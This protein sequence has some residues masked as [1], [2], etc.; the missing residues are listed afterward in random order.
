MAAGVAARLHR[1]SRRRTRRRLRVPLSGRSPRSSCGATTACCARSRTCAATAAARSATGRRTGLDGVALPVP[2]LDVGPRRSSARGAVAAGVRRARTTTTGL[3]RVA[4]DTWGPMVFVN[5]DRGR[6]RRSPT[7]S[8]ACPATSP[9]PASTSSA[10]TYL[11]SLPVPC[12]WKVVIDGFSET[13]HVQGIHREMLAIVDDVN[14][15]Q[16][17]W[18]RHGQL[19]QSLRAAVAAASGRAATTS[20]VWASFV[21]VMGGRIGVASTGR[22]RCRPSRAGRRLAALG[23]RGQDPR[24]RTRAQGVDLPALQRRPAAR[25]WSQYNLFPNITVLVFPDMLTVLRSRP[26]AHAGRG[27]SWT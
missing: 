1:R 13:Y 19:E 6:A 2:P 24:R 26:G 4:V 22:R 21:E 9:G 16:R 27:R 7:S 18:D 14:G 5:L 8:K 20:D 25:P 3:Y 12:N 11:V 15:P 10:A 23:V 17:L